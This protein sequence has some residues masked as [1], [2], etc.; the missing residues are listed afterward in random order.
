MERESRQRIE[1]AQYYLKD[2]DRILTLSVMSYEPE[3]AKNFL[4]M[5]ATEIG[6]AI[7]AM[8]NAPL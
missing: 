6:K 2:A 7:A 4:M 5:A 1:Y 8:E 3:S